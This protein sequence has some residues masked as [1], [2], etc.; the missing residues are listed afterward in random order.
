MVLT[1]SKNFTWGRSLG[2]RWLHSQ[3]TGLLRADS[4]CWELAASAGTARSPHGP[5]EEQQ[6]GE[7]CLWYCRRQVLA[8]GMRSFSF[9]ASKSVPV[10]TIVDVLMVKGAGT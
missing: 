5:L 9:Q 4:I 6:A 10:P 1:T 3:G 8:A 2:P 7:R